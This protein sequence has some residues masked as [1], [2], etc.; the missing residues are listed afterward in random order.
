MVIGTAQATTTC[1]AAKFTSDYSELYSQGPGTWTV[2]PSF[3]AG[4]TSAI[5]S[6]SESGTTVTV[7][8]TSSNPAG[9][10]IGQNVTI[11]GNSVAGYN[12]NFTVTAIPTG[13]TFQYTTASGLAAGN[14]WNGSRLLRAEQR[15]GL[16]GAAIAGYL[17]N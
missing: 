15:R 2:G 14:R 9:L 12:G 10:T 16:C 8:M 6:T 5:T 11:A 17:H 1:G 13:T 7:T 3:A 4:A